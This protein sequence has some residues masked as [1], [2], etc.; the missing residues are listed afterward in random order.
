MYA[1]SHSEDPHWN[2][3]PDRYALVPQTYAFSVEGKTVDPKQC[4]TN[5][6]ADGTDCS[7]YRRPD[8]SQF[9][10]GTEPKIADLPPRSLLRHQDR[11]PNMSP[12]KLWLIV[13]LVF[14]QPAFAQG[15]VQQGVTAQPRKVISGPRYPVATQPSNNP[16]RDPIGQGVPPAPSANS[17]Q[18]SNRTNVPTAR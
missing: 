14:S 16:F 12:L 10:E 7:D 17:Y 5:S 1:N 6:C 11:G 13:P 3:R 8:T 18:N 2:L 9:S 15:T 4:R